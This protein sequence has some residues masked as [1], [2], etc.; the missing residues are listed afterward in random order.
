VDKETIIYI[1]V[2][3]WYTAIKEQTLQKLL[4]FTKKESTNITLTDKKPLKNYIA[5]L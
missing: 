3:K 1:C 5:K 2:M 4:L